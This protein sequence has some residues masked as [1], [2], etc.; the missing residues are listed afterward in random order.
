MDIGS[1]I[2]E[3][4]N[5]RGLTITAL[6][7]KIGTTRSYISDIEHGKRTPSFEM[8]SK[9]AEALNISTDE[10]F[11]SNNDDLT[12]TLKKLIDNAKQLPEPVID[13]LNNMLESLNKN[14]MLV[15]KTINGIDTDYIV[16][17][18]K[19]PNGL[20]EE[21]ERTAQMLIHRLKELKEQNG[22]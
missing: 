8:T 22:S 19:N 5:I 16:D 6:A 13:G 17:L 9:I 2:T 10:L 4:R 12:P 20:S 1:K 7:E 21:D 11:I 15:N 3:Y 18:N 14:Y